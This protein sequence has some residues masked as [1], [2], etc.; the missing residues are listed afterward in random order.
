MDEGGGART[1]STVRERVD[2]WAPVGGLFVL[3]AAAA[4]YEIAP[5]SVTP[6]LMADLAVGEAAA[7]WIVSVMYLVAVV[8]SV[9]VGV[10]LDRTDVT[11][12]VTVAGVA[13]LVAGGAGWV[14][15]A[16]G[17]FL[18]LVA[19]RVLGGL[20][21]VTIWN[22]GADLAGRVGPA[23]SRATAVGVFTASAPAGF[24]LGQFGAPLV[25]RVA[26][27]PAIFPVFAG[28]AVFGLALYRWG[29]NQGGAG[30]TTAR[31][32]P[33]RAAVLRAFR[34]RAVWAVCGMGLAGFALYLFL[35]QWLPTYLVRRLS[36]TEATAGLLTAL[37]PAVGV[38]A[39]TGS[40]VVSDRVFAGRR[41][42][43]LVLSFGVAGPVVVGLLAVTAVGPAVA[44]VVA[45]GAAIQLG[46][47][48]LFSYVREVVPESVA[49]TAVSL[50]TAV[51]LVGAFLAPVVAGQLVELT[52]G[53]TTAFLVAGGVGVAGVLLALVAPEPARN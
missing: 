49:A 5:A 43:V 11:R 32:A 45:A 28:L 30:G 42:P 26:G 14:V 13:L 24:A 41:R 46:I 37:F 19:T 31:E 10:A 34:S 6:T 16:D 18:A 53:F 39:R 51:G 3:S 23:E 47:G 8:A 4:A 20:S 50:L 21:Y 35:N 22:A 40:G 1:P 36:V 12:A 15:A 17:R 25:A 2:T 33:T 48:L 38:L 52:G 27:W 44:L 29:S 9:P 7:G